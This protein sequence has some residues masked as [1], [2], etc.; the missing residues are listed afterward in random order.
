M[1]DRRL[2]SI[3]VIVALAMPLTAVA[4]SDGNKPEFGAA[5]ADGNGKVAV[6][7]AVEA[8]VPRAEARREDIDGD[9]KL[10]RT[11]WKFVD[12]DPVATGESGS[13]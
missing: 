6:S 4:A 5:D 9:G 1:T 3:P 2:A 8:G 12:M 11:D 13:S 10:T 7:E